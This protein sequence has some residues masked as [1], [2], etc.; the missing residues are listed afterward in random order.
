MSHLK[1]AKIIVFDLDGTLGYFS[2]ISVIWEFLKRQ[3]LFLPQHEKPLFNAVFD[4]FPEIIRPNMSAILKYVYKQKCENCC[5]QIMIYTNN[6]KQKRWAEQIAEHFEERVCALYPHKTLSTPPPPLFDQIIHAFKVNGVIVEISRTTNKKT[7]GDFLSCT[8]MPENTQICF[9]DDF[10]HENMC[11]SNVYYIHFE[12][13]VY[14]LPFST[15]FSRF[16]NNENDSIY[17]ERALSQ[18]KTTNTSFLNAANDF[19]N[20]IPFHYTKKKFGDYELDKIVSDNI[21]EK[22]RSF[23]RICEDGNCGRFIHARP[24]PVFSKKNRKKQKTIWNKTKRR[25]KN[26]L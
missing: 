4:L 5:D 7:H 2:Q 17:I 20:R 6:K 16:F 13:Y 14:H 11:N 21:L 8:K 19:A 12:P 22:L 23:F 10:L 3:C 24:V 15:M 25:K 26:A 18:F 1:N 9:L